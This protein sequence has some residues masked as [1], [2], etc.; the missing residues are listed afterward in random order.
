MHSFYKRARTSETLRLSTLALLIPTVIGSFGFLTWQI[1]RNYV[2]FCGPDAGL[3]GILCFGVVVLVIAP[4]LLLA[5]A[6]VLSRL[7]KQ[8]RNPHPL[9]VM[10]TAVFLMP[11]VAGSLGYMADV[12]YGDSALAIILLII[13]YTATS[14]ACVFFANYVFVYVADWKKRTLLLMSIFLFFG[15]QYLLQSQGAI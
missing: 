3:G 11:L 9:A 14:F 12:F 7:A 13:L 15:A 2:G 1:L 10:L 6:L 8:W 4:L 5:T